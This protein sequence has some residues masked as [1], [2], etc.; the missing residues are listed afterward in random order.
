LRLDRGKQRASRAWLE[1]AYKRAERIEKA[2]KPKK[3]KQLRL[4]GMK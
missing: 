4:W 3:T 1:A 2:M